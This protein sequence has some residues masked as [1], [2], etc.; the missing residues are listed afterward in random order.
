MSK[1]GVFYG[2]TVG[3][4]RFVAEKIGK[5]LVNAEVLSVKDL[6]KETIE[7]YDNIVLGTSTWGV[8][9]FQDDFYKFVVQLMACDLSGKTIAM[10]G[11]GDQMNYPDTYCDGMGRL[12]E[13]LRQKECTIVGR[14]PA[15][16]Y[17]F[18]ESRAYVDGKMVGLALDED[19][20]PDLTDYRIRTWIEQIKT[21][22]K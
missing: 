19:N 11:L 22:F 12:Y 14:W 10:F 5:L 17:N 3:N 13:L 4:T 8:G 21:M 9:S 6:S 7:L 15:D 2:S 18:S 20:E 1:T 16:D